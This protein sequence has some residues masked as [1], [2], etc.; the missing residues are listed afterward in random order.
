MFIKVSV[1]EYLEMS[2]CEIE[3]ISMS[4]KEV[5]CVYM[6]SDGEG[7]S[8][9]CKYEDGSYSVVGLGRDCMCDYRYMFSRVMGY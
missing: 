4:D 1:S 5:V 9:G 8:I 7:G 2:G 3:D 6:R